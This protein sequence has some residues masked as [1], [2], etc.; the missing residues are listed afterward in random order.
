MRRPWL[1]KVAKAATI[2]VRVA[3]PAPRAMGRKG[4]SSPARPS[5]RAYSIPDSI[6][7]AWSVFTAGT[8]R[9]CSTALRTGIDRKSTHLNSS[10]MSISYAV[11][12]LKKKNTINLQRR[13]LPLHKAE[14]RENTYRQPLNEARAEELELDPN[15]FLLGEEVAEYQGANDSGHGLLKRF[16]PP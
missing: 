9:L 14:M 8:F 10:H 6:P 7:T 11:F 2:S 15:V 5:L 1:A 4:G 16:G 12:C 3:S 13:R